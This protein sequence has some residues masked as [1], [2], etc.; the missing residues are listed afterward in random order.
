M[1]LKR[2]QKQIK[3]KNAYNKIHAKKEW[4]A[5]YGIKDLITDN[6]NKVRN[7]QY[8]KKEIEDLQ[9]IMVCKNKEKHT[10]QKTLL[11]LPVLQERFYKSLTKLISWG[12]CHFDYFWVYLRWK[13]KTK[14]WN[15]VTI[16]MTI[17]VDG[18]QYDSKRLYFDVFFI[19]VYFICTG[20]GKNKELNYYKFLGKL[21]DG[22]KALPQSEP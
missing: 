16:I 12:K 10:T 21:T 15:V 14:Q 9:C 19:Q 5:G 7:T 22:G 13:T 18:F 3:V 8:Q 20:R 1:L 11:F 2:W 17:S 6:R 4:Y